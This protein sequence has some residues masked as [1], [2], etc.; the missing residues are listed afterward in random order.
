MNTLIQDVRYGF[1][2]L[3]K[4]PGFTLIALITL[5]LGIGANTAIFTV[6]NG[7][8][9]Q[10]LPYPEPDRLVQLYNPTKAGGYAKIGEFSPQ[11]FD[12]LTRESKSYS[13]IASYEYMPGQTSFNLTGDGEPLRLN[14][15]VVSGQFFE[16]FPVQPITGRM[17]VR[18]DDVVGKNQQVVISESLWRKR[19]SADP[20]IA[21]RKIV[22]EG[23]PF[24]VVGVAPA[25]MQFPGP[26]VDIWGPITL[27][28]ETSVPHI[29]G[30]RW[31]N[32][33]ARL[34]PGVS[35]A[36]AQSEATVIMTRLAKLYPDSNEGHE[37]A[38]VKSLRD[39]L[40]GNVR[41]AIMVLFGTVAIVLLI[42]CANLANLALARGSGRSRELAIRAALGAGR[43]R[44][45][46]QMLTES[47][48]LSLI[49]GFIGLGIAVWTVQALIHLGAT[50][51]PRADAISIDWRVLLFSVFVSLITAALFG[52]LPAMRA[53]SFDFQS[54]LKESGYSTSEGRGKHKV[55]NALIVA[56][57]AM[58]AVLLVASILVVKSLW[59][60]TH[61]DPGFEAQ[62]VLT[63]RAVTPSE[64]KEKR[65]E[66]I[67]YRLELVRRVSEVPGV[68]S[69]GASK[70]MPLEGGGEPYG[71][72]YMGPNGKVNIKPQAGAF[73]VT[74]GYFQTLQI[75][76]IEGRTF[77][78]EDNVPNA[79]PVLIVNQALTRKYW[80]RESAIGKQ[81]LMGKT[82]LPIVGVVGD[83]RTKG[84]ANAPE[85]AIYL[86]FGQ[87]PRSVMHIFVR[88]AGNP[89]SVASAVR[90][91][92]WSYEKN[93]PIEMM[94][95]T[96]ATERQIEQPKFFTT[97]L[98]AFAGLALLLAAIG[99]YGVI[100]YNVHQQIR[101]IG[102]RMALGAQPSQVLGMVLGGALSMTAIGLAIGLVISLLASRSLG[103]LL[104]GVT[105]TDAMSYAVMSVIL[106]TIAMI[107][108][109]V[110]ARRATKVDP[111]VALR[112]E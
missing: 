82:A 48:V 80:P 47:V 7:V 78:E 21:G 62:N 25:K 53:S 74:Q 95:L 41:P 100:S 28:G 63:I 2:L 32:A 4:S 34:K 43:M 56:E 109:Y 35:A 60:L 75:P 23:Q 27:F 81:L 92:I 12:D 58:A 107:A 79:P 73:A 45:I 42:A 19:F 112:Y 30:L 66:G 88:T 33:V 102:I 26:D 76:L 49:G 105:S 64:H 10:P 52:L 106:M 94:T 39:A 16:V 36:Q 99:I 93:Q 71:F 22:L 104:F 9:L 96:S 87:M 37:R 90:Q 67:A 40:V 5:A 8:L 83:V 86:P 17:L 11:D 3:R 55:R 15:A 46:R 65:E 20:A 18:D 77:T 13:A 24:T 70:T 84:L 38:E 85:S 97:L 1:R 51:I 61:V 6:V 72:D 110:P 14:L 91:A 111:M 69:V 31:M 44:I 54:A 108:S 103:S 29:R 57:V 68:L 59:K 98:A 101:E 50:S 89:L